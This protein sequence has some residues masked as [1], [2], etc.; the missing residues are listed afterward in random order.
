MSLE[1]ELGSVS[2]KE[3]AGNVVKNGVAAAAAALIL[4]GGATAQAQELTPQTN[5]VQSGKRRAI[6]VNPSV[7]V[8]S[9]AT[10]DPN[11]SSLAAFEIG[12]AFLM[13]QIRTSGFKWNKRVEVFV[14]ACDLVDV[15]FRN[16][17]YCACPDVPGGD[18]SHVLSTGMFIKEG[19]KPEIQWQRIDNRSYLVNAWDDMNRISGYPRGTDPM[20]AGL[21]NLRENDPNFNVAKMQNYAIDIA[22]S[23]GIHPGNLKDLGRYAPNLDYEISQME[24]WLTIDAEPDSVML[25]VP[26]GIGT[27][28]HG[29]Y[30]VQ[31]FMRNGDGH[32]KD[33]I[34]KADFD[35]G[36]GKLTR[37]F[38]DPSKGYAK[39]WAGINGRKDCP[40]ILEREFGVDTQGQTEST[41][42]ID[43]LEKLQFRK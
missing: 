20:R 43:G 11:Y 37:T 27:D 35:Y 6:S 18:P 21:N 9:A 28:N 1:K 24:N 38:A 13:D 4:Y 12:D 25:V 2:W 36:S 5:T 17:D 8:T 42:Y 23:L 30:E 16:E 19:G 22:A 31:V 41:L 14:R 26:K 33:P 39:L 29:L 34:L 10:I 32:I 15:L 40:N 3:R 7:P